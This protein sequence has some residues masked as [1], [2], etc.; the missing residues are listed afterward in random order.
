VADLFISYSKEERDLTVSLARDLEAKG[1]TVWWDTGLVPGDVFEETILGQLLMAKAAIVIWSRHSAK[2]MWVRSEARRAADTGKLVPVR[3]TEIAISEIP[4]PFDGLHTVVL[5]D[6]PAIF[7]ALEKRGIVPSTQEGGRINEDDLA[8]IEWE[9]VCETDNIQDL[10]TFEQH[11]G[12]TSFAL[13][14]KARR[15]EFTFAQAERTD[16]LEDYAR[17]VELFPEG[18]HLWKARQRGAELSFAA[19]TGANTVEAFQAHLEKWPDGPYE[20][21]ARE[22]LA[23]HSY[24]LQ[25]LDQAIAR[26]IASG[27]IASQSSALLAFVA[28]LPLAEQHHWLVLSKPRTAAAL[29]RHDWNRVHQAN[30]AA[31][32]RSYLNDHPDGGHAKDARKA[33]DDLAWQ[34]ARS[35]NTMVSYAEY[36][37]TFPQGQQA[38]EAKTLLEPF[39]WQEA[40][41]RNTPESF[42]TYLQDYPV[43]AHAKEARTRIEEIRGGFVRTFDGQSGISSVAFS[44]DGQSAVSG[45]CDARKGVGMKLWDIPSGRELRTFATDRA[46]VNAVAFSPDGRYILSGAGELQLDGEDFVDVGVALK[47]WEAVSG[48]EIRA[49]SGHTRM[50]T[51]AAFSPDGRLALSGSLDRTIK[52]W[53]VSAGREVR[54]FT[55]HSGGINSVAFSPDGFALSGSTDK[56]IRLW[57]IARGSEAQTF[58]EQGARVNT[59][60]LSPDGRY[61]VS[62]SGDYQLE[63]RDQG[64]EY[65]RFYF[66]SA[67]TLW[68]TVSGRKIRTLASDGAEFKAVAFS[69]DGRC[70]LS[71]RGNGDL[72][73][74]DVATGHRLHT[75]PRKDSDIRTLAFSADGRFILSASITKLQLWNATTF[76]PAPSPKAQSL[77]VDL[78]APRVPAT[79]PTPPSQSVRPHSWW[80]RFWAG[81]P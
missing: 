43:G 10:L 4:P 34:Q 17:Y 45:I 12:W 64:S 29:D 46:N 36:L 58:S 75:F 42:G 15:D 72:E 41:A 47:L 51:C 39:L 20:R 32:Y 61:A 40:E 68:A 16:A 79:P 70:V 76:L 67:L 1:F 60:A 77:S 8:R 27:S 73:L 52:L 44:P 35:K 55:G 30:V 80:K 38:S 53:D 50:V 63:K 66:A 31:D 33:L 48:R 7:A 62:G 65:N 3:T 57:N 18:K 2:S 24:R 14:S 13:L 9:R 26:D 69:P 71:G 59:V 78:D 11:F 19:A 56:T 49:F 6:R 23:L 28:S 21:K 22:W 37:K 81:L 25:L 54:T 5:D 74:W